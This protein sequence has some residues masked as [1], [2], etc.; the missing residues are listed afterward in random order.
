MQKQIESIGSSNN[1]NRK[2][3][4][5][6]A[7]KAGNTFGKGRPA[8]S[9]SNAQVHLEQIGIDNAE[10]VYKKM[11]DLSLNGDPNGCFQACKYVLDRVMPQRRGAKIPFGISIGAKTVDELNA[12]SEKVTA[13]MIAG[14]LSPEEVIE[15]GKVIEQRFKII[16]D[17]DTVQKIE[18]T[19][20]RVKEMSV[21]AQ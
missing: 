17:T 11:I 21:G 1:E 10:A 3:I 5:A 12:L 16:T 2:N 15:V 6:H 20:A 14:E 8:G 9:K 4:P 19:C 13:M 7:F 18:K